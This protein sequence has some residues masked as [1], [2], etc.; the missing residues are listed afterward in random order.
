MFKKVSNRSSVCFG[1]GFG[2]DVQCHRTALSY[3]FGLT[4]EGNA[5]A[6]EKLFS[7]SAPR[8]RE[9]EGGREVGREGKREGG[10]EIERDYFNGGR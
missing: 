4:T 1:V 8:E 5:T 10:I 2:L 9:R 7:S 3:A 6:E